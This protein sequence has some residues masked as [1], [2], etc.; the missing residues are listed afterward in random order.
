MWNIIRHETQGRGHIKD[1]I[2]CQDKTYHLQ[3]QD[4]SIIALADGAGSA[5]FSHFGAESTT[6]K[7][8][9]LIKEKFQHYYDSKESKEVQQEI[10]STLV[11]NLESLCEATIQDL[12]TNQDSKQKRENA[13]QLL[14][15]E[16]SSFDALL[17][18][19]IH[20]D[21]IHN[22]KDGYN[23]LKADI[24]SLRNAT[25]QEL[26][27]IKEYFYKQIQKHKGINFRKK[28]K[29]L[30][31]LIKVYGEIPKK[32]GFLKKCFDWLDWLLGNN[33]ESLQAY[34]EPKEPQRQS[35]EKKR[36]ELCYKFI[37]FSCNG[38]DSKDFYWLYAKKTEAQESVKN[39]RDICNDINQKIAEVLQ[40]YQKLYDEVETQLPPMKKNEIITAET[41]GYLR[42]QNTCL[43]KRCNDII[44]QIGED[45]ITLSNELRKYFQLLL[46]KL[47]SE[48]KDFD[49]LAYNFTQRKDT[50]E[51]SIKNILTQTQTIKNTIQDF[52]NTYKD[53][54]FKHNPFNSIDSNNLHHILD[55]LLQ[56]YGNFNTTQDSLNKKLE[57]LKK[58]QYAINATPYKPLALPKNTF[59]G[60]ELLNQTLESQICELKDFA[61]TLLFVA[62]DKD[63]VLIGH[64]GDGVIGVLKQEE[65]SVASHP[66]NGEYGNETIFITTKDSYKYL[67]LIKVDIHDKNLTGF[68]LMSDGSA[69]SFYI[70]KDKKLIPLLQGDMNKAKTHKSEIDQKMKELINT[71]VR[72]KTTDDCS[73]AIMVKKGDRALISE[74]I[75]QPSIETGVTSIEGVKE[76]NQANNTQGQTIIQSSNQFANANPNQS[77]NQTP[78]QLKAQKAYNPTK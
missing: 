26:D 40:E 13:M 74:A 28:A 1:N 78:N 18:L 41:L 58:I 64:L 43:Y 10:I 73:I 57:S 60:L 46:D 66:T 35:Y 29:D 6:K 34:Q 52:K 47:E 22:I 65:L 21:T 2:P 16:I 8:A 49:S 55:R 71:K 75:K 63:K 20:T 15:K 39:F 3:D 4:F 70:N 51:T 59:Q 25:N 30:D 27:S 33:T 54:F 24:E 50:L 48:I 53:E 67:K 42:Y 14:E 17:P 11:K 7:I 62:V 19:T 23:K 36:D 32:K 12:Q 56:S 9:D 77:S 72:D 45:Y 44:K 76:P 68:V 38:F 31:R 37:S 5:K 61:S 69:E